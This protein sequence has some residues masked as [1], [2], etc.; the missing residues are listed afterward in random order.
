VFHSNV[1]LPLFRC[2]DCGFWGSKPFPFPTRDAGHS[3]GDHWIS[4]LFSLGEDPKSDAL[5]NVNNVNNVIPVSNIGMMDEENYLQR[6]HLMPLDMTASFPS[7]RDF[8]ASTEAPCLPIGSRQHVDYGHS[9]LEPHNVSDVV[10]I[11]DEEQV[12]LTSAE[13]ATDVIQSSTLHV[14]AAKYSCFPPYRPPICVADEAFFTFIDEA[15]KEHQACRFDLSR[16]SLR[17]LL[18]NV[19]V[20]CLSFR[21]FHFISDVAAPLQNLLATFWVQYLF[22]RVCC[23]CKNSQHQSSLDEEANFESVNL[24][25]MSCE[26]RRPTKISPAFC[27]PLH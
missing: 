18:G 20:D 12:R 22:L 19:P 4:T 3:D 14:K 24:S 11:N 8:H 21:L 9:L 23:P 6:P 27:V 17:R 13:F 16:P 10:T 15:R 2:A 25:G 26:P 1:I 7:N 5:P